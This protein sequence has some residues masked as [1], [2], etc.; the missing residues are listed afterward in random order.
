MRILLISLN[1][2][3]S[4]ISNCFASS[5][6]TD[7]IIGNATALAKNSIHCEDYREQQNQKEKEV[8]CDFL[9][10]EEFSFDY[11]GNN[12]K[13]WLANGFYHGNNWGEIAIYSENVDPKKIYYSHGS[14][15][16]LGKAAP[17]LSTLKYEYVPSTDM[18]PAYFILE[19]VDAGYEFGGKGY[20]QACV[21]YF[22]SEFITKRT[23]VNYVFSDLRNPACRHYF[24]SYGFQ[25]GVSEEFKSVKFDRPLHYP[26][27]WI[28]NQK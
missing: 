9:T 4:I 5:A 6:F 28:R 19:R 12:N 16:D 23:K 11:K 27:Y 21:N 14:F 10:L 3:L 1:L 24:P 13:F 26:Y 17:Y 8:R 15:S 25:A 20:S 7:E 22:I 2:F 18:H